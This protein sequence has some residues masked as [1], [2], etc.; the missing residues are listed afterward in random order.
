M[1]TD[2]QKEEIANAISDSL[3]D[4]L[5]W[6]I[7]YISSAASGWSGTKEIEEK[8]RSLPDTLRLILNNIGNAPENTYL[9]DSIEDETNAFVDYADSLLNSKENYDYLEKIW[10]KSMERNINELSKIYPK[11]SSR[12]SQAMIQ[13][14][15]DL[16][17]KIILDI[18][19]EKFNALPEIVPILRKL[20]T[21]ISQYINN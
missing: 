18:K 14:H 21:D 2:Y 1:Y 15:H 3:I 13:H 8:L 19:N 6:R 10:L 20:T 11:W 9:A 16:L 4:Q 7:L 12:D 17:K 5:L